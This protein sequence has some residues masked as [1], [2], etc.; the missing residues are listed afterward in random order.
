[1]DMCVIKQ[2]VYTCVYAHQTRYIIYVSAC[3]LCCIVRICIYE[4]LFEM[5]QK[6]E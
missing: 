2:V 4:N 1:M 6:I 5:N 3:I